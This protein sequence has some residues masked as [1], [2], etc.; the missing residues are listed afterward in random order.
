M[1]EKEKKKIFEMIPER[2]RRESFPK[3]MAVVEKYGYESE[4]ENQGRL[5]A[6]QNQ[7]FYQCLE[8]QKKFDMPSDT[9]KKNH[10]KKQNFAPP[11]K[12]DPIGDV[13]GIYLD[14]HMSSASPS[15]SKQ[16]SKHS[17]FDYGL[18]SVSNESLRTQPDFFT[19]TFAGL[20]CAH[21]T[22][23]SLLIESFAKSYGL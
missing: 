1:N 2:I 13:V 23:D 12:R 18:N 4:L 15:L 5:I 10:C 20:K 21:E 11:Q 6:L 8:N 17:I 19:Q 7:E 16:S 9:P 22:S 3:K 14:Q